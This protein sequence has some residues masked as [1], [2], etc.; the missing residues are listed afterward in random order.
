MEVAVAEAG[1]IEFD[2]IIC[3][4]DNSFVLLGKNFDNDTRLCKPL[5][6]GGVADGV[7]RANNVR[8]YNFRA[9][10]CISW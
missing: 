2:E 6:G 9:F 8:P 4:K 7:A 3:R 5:M 1:A 10:S